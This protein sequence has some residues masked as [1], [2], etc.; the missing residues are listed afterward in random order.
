VPRL[1]VYWLVLHGYRG[2]IAHGMYEPSDRADSASTTRTRWRS[3][4]R[5]STTTTACRVRQPRHAEIKR[6]E[7]DIVVYEARKAIRLLAQGNP[8][9]LSMLW[10]PEN[11]YIK[12]HR[13]RAAPARPT[14]T[15]FVGRHVYKPFV[16]YATQQLYKMEHGAFKGYMGDKRKALVERT[17][18][19]RRTPR[20]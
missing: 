17:A 12:R 20:T 9:V 13:R 11:L 5:R 8:N 18:T 14:A 19:T 7:W 2:S 3:A 10:L 15:L 6:G 16:G 4:S 1:F